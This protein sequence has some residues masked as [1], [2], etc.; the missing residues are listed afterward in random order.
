[1]I[2]SATGY[3][4][5]R[6]GTSADFLDFFYFDSAAFFWPLIL[7]SLLLIFRI[8]RKGRA[9]IASEVT[10]GVTRREIIKESFFKKNYIDV[11]FFFVGMIG[12]G[13][14]LIDEFNIPINI[15]SLTEG[16]IFFITPFAFWI[17][18]SSVGSRLTKIIPLK[19]ENSF[20]KLSMFK[21]VKNVIKSGL[22]RRGDM[23]RLSLIIILTL[24][25]ATVATI[26]GT[27]EE[28]QA[29]RNIAWQI[30]ADWQVIYNKAGDYNQNLTQIPG[31]VDSIGL[32][33]ESVK[34]YSS[35]LEVVAIDNSKELAN[36]KNGNPV[37]HW[38]KDNFDRYTP[39]QGLQILEDN[40]RALFVSSDHLM[41]LDANIG[42]VVD[43]KIPIKSSSM[44]ETAKIEDVKI[45]GVINQLPGGI[46]F[47]M[48]TS[49]QLMKE[50]KALS[51]GL[52]AD[53][54]NGIN[55]N[56]SKYFVRTE[57][58]DQI[59]TDQIKSIQYTLDGISQI[60]SH[61]SFYYEKA[62]I[63]TAAQGYGIS[64]L[65]SLDFAISLIAAL[66]S[67]FSFSAILMEKRKHEFAI[68]R[69]IGAKKKHIYKLALGENGLMML[70]ASLWGIFLG[71]GMAYLFNGVFIFVSMMSGGAGSFE[72]MVMIPGLELFVI[73]AFTLI[74]MLGAAIMSIRSSANQELALGVKE[75]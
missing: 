66:V 58:G 49:L 16:I 65:L 18:G 56:T 72:R 71:T 55:L 15:S 14:I 73:C 31:F 45:L 68:I 10:E 64:G 75:V 5:L 59:T 63:D 50:I 20:L 43:L 6:I 41:I 27:T 30:G 22:K 33:T 54:L 17:G 7:T 70:T 57:Q 11:I 19:L 74:G 8:Y 32:Y 46:S 51:L 40:P 36:L 23:D 52:N 37:I 35:G 26:Q 24:S 60:T 47:T 3:M 1:M 2:S 4:K 38:Q 44:G 48:L 29:E 21:D 9:F 13:V 39:Q 28:F 67:A 12:I 25:I 69:A 62:K 53:A 34:I 61:R 42:D